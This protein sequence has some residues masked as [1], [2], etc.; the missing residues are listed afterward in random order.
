M[1]F[2]LLISLL[3]LSTPTDLQTDVQKIVKAYVIYHADDP[4]SYEAVAFGRVEKFMS[5]YS[6]TEN[7]NYYAA[8]VNSYLDKLRQ[9]T[10]DYNSTDDVAKRKLIV[11]DMESHMKYVNE[12]TGELKKGIKAFT[13][14]QYGWK[15]Y[16]KYWLNNGNGNLKLIKDTFYLD[17]KLTIVD[18]DTIEHF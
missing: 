14:R 6:M 18:R 5:T 9:D 2:L 15:I 4:R 17:K 7:A 3:A 10:L 16:H 11:E 13:P 8:L 1:K 12:F